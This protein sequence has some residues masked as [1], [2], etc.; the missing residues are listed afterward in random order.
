MDIA[1]EKQASDIVLLDVREV[2]T[3]SDYFVICSGDNE[4]QIRT[5]Y[6]D[7]EFDLKKEGQLSHHNEG[8]IDSGWLLL[9]YG[10]VI[11]HIFSAPERAFYKLDDYWQDALP[12]IKIQ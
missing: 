8:T 5:I 7:I 6:D 4:R 10:D 9:D 11:V 12:I 3:F 1:S 2:C